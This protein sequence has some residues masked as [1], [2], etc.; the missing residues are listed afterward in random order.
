ML[1][2]AELVR[3]SRLVDDSWHCELA[4]RAAARWDL[5]Q[6][7][8]IRSSASHVFVARPAE[9]ATRVVLRM[10][11]ESPAHCA[12]LHRSAKA[13]ERLSGAGA[14][15]VAA[16]RSTAGR[17]VEIVDG[18]CVTAVAV[19]EGETR[20]DDEADRTSAHD[21][22]AALARLHASGAVLDDVPDMADLC[23]PSAAPLLTE[24][25]TDDRLAPVAV[26]VAAA[27][28][29]L[30]RDA[31]VRGTLHGDAEIDNVVF[32]ANGP[33]FVDLDDVRTGW[34]AADIA[35][36]LRAW[37][38]I[39]GAPDLSAEVPTAF[40]AGYRSHRPLTD[41]ELSWLPLFARAA[42]V[43]SLWELQPLL[44]HPTD[45]SWPQWAITLDARIRT[46]AE[47]LLN[48]ILDM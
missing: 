23:A 22:G 38:P 26:E 1:P 4:E 18:Y 34:W 35:F 21:W 42:A 3:V 39:G 40:V 6:A 44:T 27:L 5:H 10:R 13:A 33:V 2:I 25:P 17:L 19:A 20:D 15:V 36:A 47:D 7:V 30:P 32:T 16:V 29:A 14:P 37:G 12:V 48:G 24:Q 31:A 11:P 41:E 8:F 45:P 43:E 46:R 28:A 9:G